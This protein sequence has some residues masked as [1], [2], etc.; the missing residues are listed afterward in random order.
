MDLDVYNLLCT[1]L[2]FCSLIQTQTAIDHLD[3]VYKDLTRIIDF[4][5]SVCLGCDQHTYS[6]CWTSLLLPYVTWT[7]VAS[8]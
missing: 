8:V 2:F 3:C 6:I 1:L 7:L 5:L 4:I